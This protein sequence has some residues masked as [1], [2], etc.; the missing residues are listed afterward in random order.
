MMKYFLRSILVLFITVVG[1]SIYYVCDEDNFLNIDPTYEEAVFS[2]NFYY[3]TLNKKAKKYY[4]LIY[5]AS[6]EYENRI[7]CLFKYNSDDLYAAIDAFEKDFPLYAYWNVSGNT[8]SN[9]FMHKIIMD[10]DEDLD[11]ISSNRK[12]IE[13]KAK[14]IIEL[15]KIDDQYQTVLNIHDYL[16]DN[17]TYS[18]DAKD[19]HTLSGAL[20]NG[21][22]VCDGYSKAFKYLMDLLDYN[23][24]VVHGKAINQDDEPHAW[25]LIEINE[26]WY[27]V[28]V[29][30]DDNK[31]ENKYIYFL[32]T[33]QIMNL[34]HKADNN[35]IYPI[36]DDDSLFLK[37]DAYMIF[38]D[39]DYKQINEFIKNGLK[40]RHKDFYLFFND[41]QRCEEVSEYLITDKKFV[42]IYKS[43]FTLNR[44]IYYGCKEIG[45]I[46]YLYY[47]Y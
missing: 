31:N 9:L 15:C 23:C 4:S 12:Q 1:V 43:V 46:L 26:N 13:E 21:E 30:W 27:G 34:S 17:I 40:N 33:D 20:I 32:T 38:Q 16:I 5:N 22:A 18:L 24:V 2:D 45:N 37:D 19:A 10:F 14:E 28:D 6:L 35:Y 44:T 3:N 29:T 41:E 36:C 47:H 8:V 11:V 39:D 42:D 25:N 7:D